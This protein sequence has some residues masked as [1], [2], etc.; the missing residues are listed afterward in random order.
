LKIYNALIVLLS[1]RL[2][3]EEEL[4]RTRLRLDELEKENADLATSLSKREQE[5]EAKVQEKED[6]QSNLERTKEKLEM[7]MARANEARQR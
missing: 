1:Y 2:A 6:L 4:A 3:K 5:L 7:E